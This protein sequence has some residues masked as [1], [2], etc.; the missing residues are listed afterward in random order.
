MIDPF[1]SN[2]VGTNS[3]ARNALAISPD[4]DTDLTVTVRGFYLGNAGDV[5]VDMANGGSVVFSN[6]AAGVIYPIGVKRIYATGTT[7]TNIVGLY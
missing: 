1:Q 5:K 7:A 6:M 4:N 3:P 2:Q